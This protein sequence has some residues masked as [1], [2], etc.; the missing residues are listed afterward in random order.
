MCLSEQGSRSG[1]KVTPKRELM[2]SHCF[3]PAQARKSSLSETDVLAWAKT[4]GLIENAENSCF[5][6]LFELVV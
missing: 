5:Y 3:P 1:E 4:P 6:A 2:V